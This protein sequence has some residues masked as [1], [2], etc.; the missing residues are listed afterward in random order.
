MSVCIY[1]YCIHL[2]FELDVISQKAKD[3][4]SGENKK[5]EFQVVLVEFASTNP[6]DKPEPVDLIF[7]AETEP[8]DEKGYYPGVIR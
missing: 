2:N 3:I 4:D 5:I 8:L 7:Y 1:A 6:D